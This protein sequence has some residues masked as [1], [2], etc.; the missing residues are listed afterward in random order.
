MTRP[1]QRRPLRLLTSLAGHSPSVGM[2]SAPL[3]SNADANT[4]AS[5]CSRRQETGD[6]L[7]SHG[8]QAPCGSSSEGRHVSLHSLPGHLR[9][10]P[11]QVHTR[12][13]AVRWSRAA[14][15]RRAD[16]ARPLRL[17]VV[18]RTVVSGYEATVAPRLVSPSVD[19]ARP[20][21]P[22]EETPPVAPPL[23]PTPR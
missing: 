11:R 2:R 9:P 23:L 4:T 21:T 19:R 14:V 1:E 3:P 18:A 20:R 15:F 8:A 12:T 7:G 16:T 22:R 17:V 6:A 13:T 5:L 10:G